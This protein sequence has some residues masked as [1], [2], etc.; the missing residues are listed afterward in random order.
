MSALAAC[1]VGAGVSALVE[2][3]LVFSCAFEGVMFSSDCLS[4]RVIWVVSRVEDGMFD[5]FGVSLFLSDV[6]ED[7]VIRI[8]WFEFWVFWEREVLVLAVSVEFFDQFHFAG[9]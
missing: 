6:F 4:I 5:D 9:V 7:C 3:L 1:C 8:I 2:E